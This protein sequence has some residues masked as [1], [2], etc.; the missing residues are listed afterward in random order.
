MKFRPGRTDARTGG[1][2]TPNKKVTAIYSSPQA[3]YIQIE[4]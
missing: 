3:D 2:K 4:F 1:R